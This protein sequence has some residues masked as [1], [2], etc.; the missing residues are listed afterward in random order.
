MKDVHIVISADDSSPN[1]SAITNHKS[2][3]ISAITNI[4]NSW[5]YS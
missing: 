4:K 2:P 1:I 5:S 3:N